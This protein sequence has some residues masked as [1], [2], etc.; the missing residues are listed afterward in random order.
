[1]FSNTSKEFAFFVLT[2]QRKAYKITCFF[3]YNISF[4]LCICIKLFK[5]ERD[6]ILNITNLNLKLYENYE[7]ITCKR[8]TSCMLPMSF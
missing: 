7:T 6:K 2:L 3:I 8:H 1:M 5:K 4:Y